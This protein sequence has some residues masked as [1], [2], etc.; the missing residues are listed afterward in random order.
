V[1][2]YR[3]QSKERR[4]RTAIHDG[5][6]YRGQYANYGI[7]DKPRAPAVHDLVW[8]HCGGREDADTRAKPAQ[9]VFKVVEEG[10]R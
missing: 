3:Q 4:C 7:A 5:E 2:S 1:I 9:G 10:L 8:P 6:H